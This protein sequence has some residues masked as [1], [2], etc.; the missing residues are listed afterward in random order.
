[1]KKLMAGTM[2]VMVVI[3]M[4]M[5]AAPAHAMVAP[6]FLI[7]PGHG[8]GPISVGESL[9]SVNATLGTPRIEEDT[10]NGLPRVSPRWRASWVLLSGPYAPLTIFEALV[11]EQYGTKEIENLEIYANPAYR[12]LEGIG[13]R[14]TITQVRA[15]YGDA[16][17]QHADEN[18]LVWAYG[19]RGITFQF[20][21][22]HGTYQVAFIRVFHPFS[23]GD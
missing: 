23:F 17:Y 1:M 9:D 10:P 2:L 5:G 3:G 18:S 20:V 13:V 11:S 6:M 19:R 22:D 4:A 21:Y 7:L 8:I 16:P 12:T 14:S 15:A